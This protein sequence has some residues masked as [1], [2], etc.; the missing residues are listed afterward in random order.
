[1][2]VILLFAVALTTLLRASVPLRA[3]LGAMMMVAHVVIVIYG[4]LVIYIY[5]Y[6]VARAFWIYS[7]SDVTHKKKSPTFVVPFFSTPK[8]AGLLFFFS[9]L[10]G[11]S[12]QK[13]Y[14][15]G[16]KRR[17]GHTLSLSPSFVLTS[18][19]TP[20]KKT[21]IRGLYKKRGKER[22]HT[23]TKKKKRPKDDKK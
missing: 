13:L 19:T 9:L 2:A 4:V 10:L 23:H 8:S 6:I 21:L 20:L 3:A 15:V 12:R 1:M 17:G 14:G 7:S 16:P 5:I 18:E 11:N 22:D